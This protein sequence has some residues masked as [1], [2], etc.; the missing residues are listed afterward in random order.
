M[1]FLFSPFIFRLSLWKHG[2]NQI[3]ELLK[4]FG[5]S[6]LRRMNSRHREALPFIR[7]YVCSTCIWTLLNVGFLDELSAKG[8]LDLDAYASEKKLDPEILHFI[9]EYMD[10]LKFLRLEGGKCRLDKKGRRFLEEP[11]GLFDL[12]YGYEPIFYAL[13]DLLTKRKAYRR[14]VTRRSDAVARGSGEL[15]RQLPFPVMRDIIQGRGF[16]AVLDIG[17]GDAEFLG[18]LCEDRQMRCW[19]FDV[20]AEAVACA[21]EYISKAGLNGRI[22]V[23]Q[24]D[25]FDL[26]NKPSEWPPAEAFTVVDVFHEYLYGGQ[27]RIAGLLAALKKNFPDRFLIVAEFCRQPHE[28]LRRRPTAFLEHHLFHNLTQQVILSEAERRIFDLVGHGYFLLK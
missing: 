9:C 6:K 3:I 20:S 1:S 5:F 12:L 19:G 17:C 27:E 25:M 22:S 28:R 15:G 7:G 24:G 2:M 10:G 11:R 26:V 21:K 18:V 16:R 8:T 23:Y 13:E 14:D 4:L